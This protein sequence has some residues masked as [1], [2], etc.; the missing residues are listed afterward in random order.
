MPLAQFDWDEAKNAANNEK[1]QVSF[2]QAQWAFADTRRVLARNLEY[3][4]TEEHEKENQL[5]R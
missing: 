3:S 1:H 5:H 4:E 2:E